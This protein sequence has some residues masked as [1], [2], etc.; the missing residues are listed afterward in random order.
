MSF[1]ARKYTR[2]LKRYDQ[3]LFCAHNM[4]HVLCVF[5]KHKRY[6]PV[7]VTDGFKL[8][9]LTVDKQYVFSL[10]EDWTLKSKPRA[11]GVDFVLNHLRE[12]DFF[13][14]EALVDEIERKNEQVDKSKERHFQNEAEAFWSDNRRAFAKATD[15][16]LTHSLSKDEP[17]KRLKDRSIKNG[18][19]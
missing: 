6:L 15:H 18:N 10:T 8:M 1:E 17:R 14:N 4:D 12:I 9:N 16:I 5:R 7:C 2:A 3:D 19:S 13:A 11:W